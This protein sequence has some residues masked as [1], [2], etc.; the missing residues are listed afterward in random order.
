[1]A[2][3]P[4]HPLLDTVEAYGKLQ[5]PVWPRRKHQD[6]L[7]RDALLRNCEERGGADA[8]SAG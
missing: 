2:L 8:G 4:K 7:D 3:P 5:L 1:M 6:H